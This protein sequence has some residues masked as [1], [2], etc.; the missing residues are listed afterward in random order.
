[1]LQRPLSLWIVV[2]AAQAALGYVQ[3][4]LDVPAV[5]VGFHVVGAILVM[6]AATRLQLAVT[7]PGQVVGGRRDPADTTG[8]EDPV[9]VPLRQ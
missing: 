3:Y 7:R 6:W 4:V 9:E 5:L 2:A 8:A 1:M